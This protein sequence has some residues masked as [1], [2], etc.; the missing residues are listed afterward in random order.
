MRLRQAI[1]DFV[2]ALELTEAEREKAARQHTVLRER[3]SQQL[4]LDPEHQT[5][6]TGSYARRTAIRP[7]DD[8]DMFCVLTEEVRSSSPRQVQR[9]VKLAL[10]RAYPGKA[11]EPRNRAVKIEFSETGIAYD[12]VPAISNR[13]GS[14]HIPDRQGDRWILSNPKFHQDRATRANQ[15]AGGELKPLTKVAKHWN[16]H[17]PDRNRLSSFHIE[18]MAWEA[19]TAPPQDRAHGLVTLFR[20]LARRVLAP[21]PDPAGLGPDIDAGLT[22]RE[23]AARRLQDV[24]DTIDRA[25]AEDAAGRTERAHDLLRQL[26][27]EPYPA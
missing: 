17:R 8:I 6:L 25:I 5:F 4:N 2:S 26:F 1:H 9:H 19:M 23:G 22:D 14:F 16:R 24:A 7:L 11:A 15:R 20:F 21:T 13:L 3:L 27:G 10:D 18:V 12:V